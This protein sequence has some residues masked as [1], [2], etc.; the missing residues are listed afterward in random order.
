MT[1]DER[2]RDIQVII[3]YYYYKGALLTVMCISLGT[4]GKKLSA[5]HSIKSRPLHHKHSITLGV[6]YSRVYL[7][8]MFYVILSNIQA[9]IHC[10]FK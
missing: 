4:Q 5:N 1:C 10:I 2:D 9:E 8:T 6:V 3:K 7:S